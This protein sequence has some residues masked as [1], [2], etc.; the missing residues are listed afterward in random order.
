[1]TARFDRRPA[2]SPISGS[3]SRLCRDDSADLGQECDSDELA[4]DDLAQLTGIDVRQ[5]REFIARGWLQ[6]CSRKCQSGAT[7]VTCVTVH[8]VRS[9]I[10][11]RPEVLDYRSARREARIRLELDSLPDP[12]VYKRLMCMSIESHRAQ[13]LRSWRDVSE[14]VGEAMPIACRRAI[15]SCA[16][17]GGTVFWA[18]T[19][20]TPSCP[21]CGCTV[22]PYSPDGVYA[23]AEPGD[24]N[25]LEE[26]ARNLGLRWVRGELRNSYG[27]AVRRGHV[28]FHLFAGGLND[29]RPGGMD[30]RL[31][32]SAPDLGHSVPS[33]QDN[34]MSH[35]PG[36]EPCAKPVAAFAEITRTVR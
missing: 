15:T 36:V 17:A 20:A 21:R 26:L 13:P 33:A 19:Y 34:R 30:G 11:R 12:P 8:R 16:P 14:G 32:E 7:Q 22:S 29:D 1:M 4:L 6:T 27:T 10:K 9:L 28:L 18:P 25:V 3:D 35:F 2:I 5:W 31:V 24:K 23:D